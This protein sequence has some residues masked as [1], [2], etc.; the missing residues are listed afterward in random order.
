[1]TTYLNPDASHPQE[2]CLPPGDA[3]PPDIRD[4]QPPQTMDSTGLPPA[5]L[6]PVSLAVG[7]SDIPSVASEPPVSSTNTGNG[8]NNR[9]PSGQ[10][11]MGL[12]PDHSPPPASTPHLVR[13][14]N[15]VLF[16][17]AVL[18]CLRYVLPTVVEETQYAIT[19][20]RQRAE[21]DTAGEHLQNASL[22]SI[23]QAYQRVFQRVAPSVVHIETRNQTTSV[24]TS[25]ASSSLRDFRPRSK[26]DRSQGSGVI[27]SA[28]GYVI[29]N[30][31]VIEGST[32]IQVK[33]S[34]GRRMPARAIGVDRLTD[35]ALLKIEAEN[36]TAAEWGDS[37]ALEEGAP[38]WA[39][40]SPFGFQHSITSGILSAK[41]RGS[42]GTPHQ[43]FL[44][45]DA[46]VNPGNSGGPL[47]DSKGRVIGINTMIV[48]HSFQGVSLAIPCNVA[49]SVFERLRD[50]G[51][52]VRG[53]L[54]VQLETVTAELNQVMELG[55]DQGAVVLRIHDTDSMPSPARQ[56]GIRVGDVIV[57]WG[58]VPVQSHPQLSR[59]IAD[60]II[61]VEVPVTVIRRGQSITIPVAIGQRPDFWN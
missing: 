45:T 34:D 47:V 39:V 3:S 43:N 6:P 48:G 4:G 36:L 18:L 19:R 14:I 26:S 1:M 7:Q 57:K 38:V 46:A 20:G 54:G 49:R 30:Y 23:S 58:D 56:A 28:D 25:G 29:T 35:L 32:H 44:Q 31:H 60:A 24:S 8:N 59:Q 21:Y 12:Y 41:N 27:V 15:R 10:V 51:T 37:K 5:D 52:V 9:V 42:A 16:L 2:K 33:L 11:I 22:N 61:G 55:T 17:I 40:G 53:Y 50:Q 13:L